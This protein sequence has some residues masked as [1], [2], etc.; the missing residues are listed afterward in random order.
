M[1]HT[2]RTLFLALVLG[3]TS[4]AVAQ[5]EP[6]S[7]N[8]GSVY[9]VTMVRTDA[10]SQQEYLEQLAKMYIPTME[11]AKKAGLIKSYLLLTGD[12]A[13]EDDFNVLMLTEFENMAALDE[14]PEKKAKWKALR[15]SVRDQQGGK[16]AVDAIRDSYHDMRTMVGNKIMRQQVLKP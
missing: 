2:L 4:I 3:S 13:N 11:A 8:S 1:K 15:T 5:D 6:D 7:Y 12:F 16:A 14:T 10:N 9:R